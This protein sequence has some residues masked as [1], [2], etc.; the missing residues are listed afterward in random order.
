MAGSSVTT[1]AGNT[2]IGGNAGKL[3]NTGTNEA[4]GYNALQANTS[5]TLNV[6]L[7]QDSLY[8]NQQGDQSIA[9]GYQALYTQNPSGNAYMH[10]IAIGCEAAKLITTGTHNIAIGSNALDAEDTGQRNVAIGYNALTAQDASGTVQNTALGYEAG[11]FVSTGV[12]NTLIGASAGD[13]LTT[14]NRNTII[15]SLADPSAAAGANQV[16]IGYAAAGVE[17]NSVTIGSSSYTS[18]QYLYGAVNSI[19]ATADA[20]GGGIDAATIETSVAEYNS[21]IITTIY[22]DIGGGSIVS[23]SSAGDVIGEDGVAA[24]YL[25]RLTEA[26][27]GIVYRVEMVCLEAPTTG[28]PDINLCAN[29][30][31]TIAE[32]A[33]G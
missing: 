16:V 24:A 15:G 27:N 6:A 4:L 26:K 12:D 2:L 30:S 1:G 11:K 9:V 3:V 22:I 19:K 5:G 31:G 8:T 7:G 32:D 14:G 21:E 23:S 10:N 33:S 18:N 20:P 25:T 29:S 13:V 17:D 28:D